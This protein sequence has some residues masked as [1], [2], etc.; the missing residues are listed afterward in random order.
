[1]WLSSGLP[2]RWRLAC[3]LP[4]KT[5]GM[6]RSATWP[7]WVM[8]VVPA[9][10]LFRM[11][12]KAEGRPPTRSAMRRLSFSRPPPI[13]IA[14]TG[15]GDSVSAL[16]RVELRA[17]TIVQTTAQLPAHLRGGERNL[18]G[19]RRSVLSICPDHRHR[20][21]TDYPLPMAVSSA[22]RHDRNAPSAARPTPPRAVTDAGHRTAKIGCR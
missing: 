14:E 6:C 13:R 18:A 2:V 15:H 12:P 17:G 8:S 19:P 1:V 9:A 3:S 11:R 4:K 7:E 10:A 22:L 21:R 16:E 20:A 5:E